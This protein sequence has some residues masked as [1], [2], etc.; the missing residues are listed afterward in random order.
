MKLHNVNLCICALMS[1]AV[2]FQISCSECKSNRDC[3][4]GEMC[5]GGSCIFPEEWNSGTDPADTDTDT[6]SSFIIPIGDA[7]AD[8]DVDPGGDTESDSA[9]DTNTDTDSVNSVDSDSNSTFDTDGLPECYE[10]DYIIDSF[11][12]QDIF[13]GETCI[14][15]GLSI[16]EAFDL[17]EI[18]LPNLR[19][20][21]DSLLIVGN[22]SL[23]EIGYLSALEWIGK[24]LQISANRILAGT[25]GLENL[26]YVGGDIRILDNDDLVDMSGF[27]ALTSVGESLNISSNLSLFNADGFDSLF[28]IEDELRIYDN[29]ALKDIAGFSKLTYVGGVMSCTANA[30]LPYCELCDLLQGLEAGPSI[31]IHAGNLEDDCL[32]YIESCIEN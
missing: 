27:T 24:D 10:G 15:G 4:T 2:F 32:G 22:T 21:R 9:T 25:N 5:S 29:G 20:V 26:R 14:A 18:N 3:Q 23:F 28:R 17:Y 12:A 8:A 6:S 7:D 30:Q 31:L 19:F 11:D 16:I 13:V 1:L